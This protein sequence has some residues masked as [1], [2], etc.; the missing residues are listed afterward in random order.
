MA[1]SDARTE[2]NVVAV[3]ILT[4]ADV[5]VIVVTWSHHLVRQ[6]KHGYARIFFADATARNDDKHGF[7]RGRVRPLKPLRHN[8]FGRR[9]LLALP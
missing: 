9:T 3:V 5:V 6:L 2:R 1:D 7:A 8:A 4:S